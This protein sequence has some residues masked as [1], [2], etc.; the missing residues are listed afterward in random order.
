MSKKYFYL[1]FIDYNRAKTQ[2]NAKYIKENILIKILIATHSHLSS[3][4]KDAVELICGESQHI[5]IMS[6]YH[7]TSIEEFTQAV[8]KTIE[9]SIKQGESILALVD[10]YGA[11]PFKA[12]ALSSKNIDPEN[13]RIISGVNLPMAIEAVMSRH[14]TLNELYVSVLQTGKESIKEFF[15]ELK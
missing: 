14:L 4:L 1:I 2:Q 12:C 7:E 5:E 15:N 9:T 10:I 13:Y 11:S 6:L 8:A 3:A